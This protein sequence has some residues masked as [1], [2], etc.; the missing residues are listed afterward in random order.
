MSC[1]RSHTL[2]CSLW[3]KMNMSHHQGNLKSLPQISALK[4][5]IRL[6]VSAIPVTGTRGVRVCESVCVRERDSGETDAYDWRS[7]TRMCERSDQNFHLHKLIN[8][9]NGLDVIF[10]H[11]SR[12]NGIQFK[13]SLRFH[14]AWNVIFVWR[15]FQ[16]KGL[17]K[18]DN[19]NEWG[20]M[21]VWCNFPLI[22]H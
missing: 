7:S 11:H 4:E 9:L 22:T 8:Q 2:Y 15:L 12:V 6:C 3:C 21:A 5:R 13:T 1:W 16:G 18:S 19:G 17:K 10:I 14:T 20:N